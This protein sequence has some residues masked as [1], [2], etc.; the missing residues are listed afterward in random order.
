MIR[1][2]DYR[3]LNANARLY[4]IDA[5]NEIYALK[6]EF[7]SPLTKLKEGSIIWAKVDDGYFVYE[8]TES[9]PVSTEEEIEESIRRIAELLKSYL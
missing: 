6:H 3:P 7:F 8:L 4:R 2:L 5:A 9:L 1:F